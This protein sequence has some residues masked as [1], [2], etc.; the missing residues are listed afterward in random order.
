MISRILLA[1]AALLSAQSA[2]ARDWPETGGW[3]IVQG[4][5]MCAMSNEFE[6]PGDS[7]LF[8]VMGVDGII[9]MT[10][11]NSEWTSVEGEIY[12]D[13]TAVMDGTV[14]GGS[15]A[16]GAELD[17]KK[18]FTVKLDPTMLEAIGAGRSIHLYRGD[19]RMDHL[20]LSGTGAAIAMTRR[21]LAD[22]RA[23]RAAAERETRRFSTLERDPFA[24][25]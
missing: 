9:L 5:T 1:A 8:I 12:D 14:Y 3:T 6:G 16:V 15:R 2:V 20:N 13:I 11:V 22:L 4:E 18:G 24:K 19:L 25:R 17:G 21:C 23:T 7:E 10:D